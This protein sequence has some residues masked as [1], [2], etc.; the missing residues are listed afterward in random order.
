MNAGLFFAVLYL[1]LTLTCQSVWV[2]PDWVDPGWLAECGYL[3]R[4]LSGI[5][6][7]SWRTWWR[8]CSHAS[9][10]DAGTEP[11]ETWT[12]FHLPGLE[13]QGSPHLLLHRPPLA[14]Q[15]WRCCPRPRWWGT[16][17]C[18]SGKGGRA[19]R[20]QRGSQGCRSRRRGGGQVWWSGT[21]V[22]SKGIRHKSEGIAR[23][24]H[25]KNKCAFWKR[26][27]RWLPL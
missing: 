14:A 16:P 7:T 12:H 13:P 26:I 25:S 22:R 11:S 6:A 23:G 4:Q 10:D 1:S 27:S 3:S 2:E 9:A 5:W 20:W 15:R 17:G 24:F 21:A 8:G 19:S 18:G